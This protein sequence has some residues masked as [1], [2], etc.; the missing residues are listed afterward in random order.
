MVKLDVSFKQKKHIKVQ[1]NIKVLQAFFCQHYGFTRS[2]HK[3][4]GLAISCTFKV[5]RDSKNCA[6][7]YYI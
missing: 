3:I 1:K 6:F 4:E 2:H 7:Y 5:I